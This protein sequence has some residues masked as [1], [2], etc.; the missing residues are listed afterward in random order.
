[1][2]AAAGAVLVG[3]ATIL[4]LVLLRRSGVFE[5]TL[6]EFTLWSVVVGAMTIAFLGLLYV[7][8]RAP[9][10]PRRTRSFLFCLFGAIWG[11]IA[12][13]VYWVFPK[14]EFCVGGG[15]DYDYC[16]WSFLG[17]VQTSPWRSLVLLV[18][19]GVI[20]GAVGGVT[21]AWLTRGSQASSPLRT[22]SR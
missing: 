16:G 14:E 1:M 13:V 4:G 21:A 17:M 19:V 5:L 11:L 9:S 22:E 10:V 3:M 15:I 7:K 2:L 20:L 18:A 12:G 6:P 8:M